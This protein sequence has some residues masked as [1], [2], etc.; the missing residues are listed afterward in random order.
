MNQ[1]AKSFQLYFYQNS[2]VIVGKSIQTNSLTFTSEMT[3]SLNVKELKDVLWIQI[4][5][6][7]NVIL[8]PKK[9]QTLIG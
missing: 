1:D 6:K 8:N 2:K 3:I 9:I 7:F 5:N 4:D